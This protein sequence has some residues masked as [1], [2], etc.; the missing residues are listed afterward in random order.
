MRSAASCLA[1]RG[2]SG[3]RRLLVNQEYSHRT[4]QPPTTSDRTFHPTKK[5]S[6][7]QPHQPTIAA[8]SHKQ[9]SPLF[10]RQTIDRIP[11]IPKNDLTSHIPSKAI[12]SPHPPTSDHFNAQHQNSDRMYP[13]PSISQDSHHSIFIEKLQFQ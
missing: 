5:R 1:P 9:R 3:S 12:A 7:T 6:P 13:I 10:S 11:N 8:S 4:T 2:T